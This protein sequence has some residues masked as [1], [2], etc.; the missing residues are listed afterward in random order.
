MEQWRSKPKRYPHFALPLSASKTEALVYS[1]ELVASHAFHPFITY[2]KKWRRFKKDGTRKKKGSTY[3]VRFINRC[4]H[5]LLLPTHP[6]PA[7]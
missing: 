2:D 5:I 1:P 6:F 3:Q 7:L 4:K